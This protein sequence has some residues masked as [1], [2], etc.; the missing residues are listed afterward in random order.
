MIHILFRRPER[1]D[2]GVSFSRKM[3]ACLLVFVYV[4]VRLYIHIEIDHVENTQSRVLS[5]LDFECR[6]QYNNKDESLLKLET[7]IHC[8]W[9]SFDE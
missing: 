1:Y 4:N 7:K 9:L 8:S 5:M 2:A 6:Q 3:L